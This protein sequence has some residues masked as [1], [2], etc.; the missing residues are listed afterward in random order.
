[1]TRGTILC[2]T[3]DPRDA[4]KISQNDCNQCFH[5]DSE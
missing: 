2:S 3:M 1:L 5:L 4:R